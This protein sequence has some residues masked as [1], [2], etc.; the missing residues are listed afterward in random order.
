VSLPYRMLLS[1]SH[2]SLNIPLIIV[3]F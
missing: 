2:S 1:Q 3:I